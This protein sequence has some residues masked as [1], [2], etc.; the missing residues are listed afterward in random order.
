ML[1]G[2]GRHRRPRQAPALLVAAG[3]TGSVIA[4]PLLTAGG[5]SAASG[6]TWDKV[7]EC[8]SGGAWSADDGGGHYGGLQLTQDEWEA[9]GGLDYA[10]SP[11]RASRSQ[12]IAV[13][14]RILADQGVG[15]W[16]VCGPLQGLAQDSAP[17]GVDTG[18]AG[19]PTPDASESGS[20]SDGSSGGTGGLTD[21]SKSSDGSGDSSAGSDSFGSAD[22]PAAPGSSIEPGS[23]PTGSP[24]DSQADSQ[25]DSP[26]GGATDSPS[27]SAG[28]AD[29]SDASSAPS[30]GQG[31]P[32]APGGADDASGGSLPSISPVEPPNESSSG[33]T[34]AE[35]DNFQQSLGSSHLVDTGA[36]PEVDP[37]PGSGRHRGGSA[38]ESD[39]K[40]PTG[41]AGDPSASS[42]SPDAPAPLNTPAPLNAP[43][44]SDSSDSP[45]SSGTPDTSGT[46]SS[47]GR[48]AARGGGDAQDA[49]GRSYTV[50]PGDTLTSI[51]DSLEVDGGWRQIFQQNE[52]VLD[53]DPNH[54]VPG[55]T[56]DIGAE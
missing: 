51:A 17:A 13:A 24:T 45:D 9:Y 1:S 3:V 36:L 29:P 40:A 7:A 55:Q 8:E 16:P 41:R 54:I 12:Q 6:T 44:S 19:D 31:T 11:D 27:G 56:L 23:S 38:D 43:D 30:G 21:S 53:G 39:V 32:G 33:P 47:S 52:T 2:N 34:G 37:L 10:S 28:P 5:A 20:G 49:L 46:S 22:D 48:H 26:T 15:V 50:R 25:A 14:E 35:S 4:I 42:A 18:V